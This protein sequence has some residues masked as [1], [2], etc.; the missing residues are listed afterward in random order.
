MKKREKEESLLTGRRCARIDFCHVSDQQ[1]NLVRVAPFIV[2][3]RNE[4]DKGIGQTDARVR[5]EN[6]G[7]G[8]SEKIG[9]NYLVF[10]VAEDALQLAL[11]GFANGGADF[12][13]VAGRARLA[14]RSTTETSRVGTRKAIPVSFPSSS[15]M[16]LPTALAAPVEEGM[17]LPDAARPPRQSFREG[18]STVFWVAVVE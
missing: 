17:I 18:P 5:V 11:R 10:G 7:V 1:Q 2:I 8:V 12:F 3:P 4:L 13:F 15:G 16:T 6:R 9:G 14:V